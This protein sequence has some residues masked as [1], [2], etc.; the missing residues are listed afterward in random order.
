MEEE[1]EEETQH[2]VWKRWLQQLEQEEVEE[3][4]QGEGNKEEQE[5]MQGA[6]VGISSCPS[7]FPP[8]ASDTVSPHSG[9]GTLTH[10][11]IF[12]PSAHT[13]THTPTHNPGHRDTQSAMHALERYS[14]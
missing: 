2:E 4:V 12:C 8:P 14:R 6:Q 9:T 1:E 10:K 13:Y 11:G 7:C 5:A 3:E